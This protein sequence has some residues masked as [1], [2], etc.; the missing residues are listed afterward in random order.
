MVNVSYRIGRQLLE[1]DCSASA[2][3]LANTAGSFAYVDAVPSSKFQGFFI[4]ERGI[5]RTLE[6]VEAAGD[7]SLVEHRFHSVVRRKGSVSETFFLPHSFNALCYEASPKALVSV[8]LD[9]RAAYDMRQF[10][11]FYRVYEKDSIHVIEFVKKTDSREDSSNGVDEFRLYVALKCDGLWSG[12]GNWIKRVYA[13]DRARNS[14]WERYV[15]HA[16]DVSACR[17]V[18]AASRDEALA[19]SQAAYAFENFESLM[20]GQKRYFS[21]FNS[22]SMPV[23]A[24]KAS[25]D[26]LVNKSGIY[27]GIPWFFQEWSRDSL[28]ALPAAHE[29]IQKLAVMRFVRSLGE[30][31]RLLNVRGSNLGSSDSV[32]WLFL[33]AAQL[34]R[35]GVFSSSEREEVAAALESS[36]ALQDKNAVDGLVFSRRNESWMDTAFN[37][38]GREGFPVEVQALTL[39]SYEFLFKLREDIKVKQKIAAMVKAV[40]QRFWNGSYLADLAGDFTIRPNIFIAAYAYGKL[41]SK[42]EWELCIDSVLPRLWLEWGGIATI[43]RSSPLFQQSHTGE[44]NRSYHRGDSW[45]WLNNLAAIVMHSINRVKYRTFIE[46]IKSASVNDLLWQGAAGCC[47][48][49]SSAGRQSAGGCLSQAWSCSTLIELLS[50]E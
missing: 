28:V 42:K 49:L 5:F 6:S 7:V 35:K 2:F 50:L 29:Y 21:Q 17:I 31:G 13:L 36:L 12:V 9:C 22:D 43:D 20:A 47:S 1:K 23:A 40:R 41:L 16:A 10:G 33:R 37:D 34:F 14:S 19:V 32:G 24:A 8:F 18:V 44:D 27:A 25:F 26:S 3:I 30:D 38:N 4:N 11:R 39:A 15:Y 45:Y 46:K 48:E